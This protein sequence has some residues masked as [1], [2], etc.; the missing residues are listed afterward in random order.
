[1]NVE[2][3]IRPGDNVTLLCDCYST[4]GWDIHWVR[5][6]TPLV[7]PIAISSY[8]SLIRPIA[9]YSVGQSS[10]LTI[11]N[12]TESDLGFYYCA[13]VESKP[14]NGKHSKVTDEEIYRICNTSTKLLFEGNITVLAFLIN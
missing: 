9:R 14:S 5:G 11:E 4:V 3:V 10:S 1:M 12:I 13:K 2:R 7:Q 8:E 6:C